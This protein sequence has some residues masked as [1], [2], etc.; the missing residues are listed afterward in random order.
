[1]LIGVMIIGIVLFILVV[2]QSA[3]VVAYWLQ[4][5][6]PR[7][8]VDS[9]TL[10]KAAVILSLRGADPYLHRTLSALLAQDYPDYAVFLV[11]DH[12]DD[13][14]WKYVNQFIE[15]NPGA[16][17]VATP[18]ESP[19][20][21]CGLKCSALMQAVDV[22]DD[23]YQVAAFTDADV[24]PHPLW[25]RDLVI[26]LEDSRVGVSTGNRWFV[27]AQGDWGSLFRY[28]W[29][30]GAVVQVWYNKIVWGGSMAMRLDVIRD[31]QILPAWSRSLADDSVV[32]SQMKEHG[33]RI[34]FVPQAM[35]LN[36]EQIRFGSFY[37]WVQRQLVIAKSCDSQWALIPIHAF[38][39][40]ALQ[41]LGAF[42]VW[43][44]WRLQND[45]V[46]W[47]CAVS[48]LS[49]WVSTLGTVVLLENT[50]RNI[51]YR[52]QGKSIS[53]GWR[54]RIR[55]FPTVLATHLVYPWALASAMWRRRI[56]WRGIEYDIDGQGN[57]AMTSYR[58]YQ[59]TSGGVDATD[60]LT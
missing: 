13:P 30:I 32:S 48:W 3:I 24:I 60:S 38:N 39:L 44:S 40:A 28:V 25:L 2:I 10:P 51:S 9:S 6:Q 56:V 41:L 46:M 37:G 58:P 1:M 29:N 54:S 57:V 31:T 19:S 21:N 53:S 52:N 50:I 47:F 12:P 34:A 33:Y 45:A 5:R 42:S 36:E 20:P 7:P 11:V 59:E 55:V 27:P 18:L 16:R 35:M 43:G 17:I 8:T 23:S 4:L 26:P 22:L 14:A 49:Y 15:E